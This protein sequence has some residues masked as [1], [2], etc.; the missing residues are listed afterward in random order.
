MYSLTR[1]SL[2]PGNVGPAVVNPG[3]IA[4]VSSLP[5]AHRA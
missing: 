2:H 4:I 3:V 5:H 1:L